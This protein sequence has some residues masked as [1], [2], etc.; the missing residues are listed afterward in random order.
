M[1]R[2]LLVSALFASF[3]TVVD[4]HAEIP[5]LG[6]FRKKNPDKDEPQPKSK[7]IVETLKSDTD[8]KKRQAA[9]VQLRDEDPRT[10]ADILPTLIASLQRDPS[11][12][13]R[14]EVAE[15]IGKLKPVSQVA[16]AALEQTF[17]SDPSESVRKSSQK[18]LWDY[19]LNGY[20]STGA[21]AAMP[22]TAEPPLAKPKSAP[23]ALPVSRQKP[24]TTATAV[25]PPA[26]TPAPARPITTGIGKGAI[27][28]QTIEPPLAK[29]KETAIVP[30]VPSIQVPP[31]PKNDNPGIAIPTPVELPSI[32]KVTDGVPTIPPLPATP[33]IPPPN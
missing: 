4:V 33:S 31:L 13:V 22:Q 6:I 8:E 3:A 32:P 10:N 23:I 2:W 11:T 7:Q 18:A 29:P 9:A 27:Y 5:R 14:S 19:H 1:S 30:P 12:A 25:A 26:T 17:V 16:G 28:P 24:L 20:R 15:T 21:N